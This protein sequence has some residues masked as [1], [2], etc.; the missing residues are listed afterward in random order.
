MD[1][2]VLFRYENS[3]HLQKKPLCHIFAAWNMVML[4]YMLFTTQ[5]ILTEGR[6]EVEWR[7]EGARDGEDVE[8]EGGQQ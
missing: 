1:K 5:Y 8:E 3:M 6:W 4:C 7:K 2:P